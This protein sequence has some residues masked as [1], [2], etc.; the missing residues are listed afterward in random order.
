[1]SK[2]AL[3]GITHAICLELADNGIRNFFVSPN[4]VDYGI[5][6]WMSVED[7]DT[8]PGFYLGPGSFPDS[9]QE[10]FSPISEEAVVLKL[11]TVVP[12]LYLHVATLVDYKVSSSIYHYSQQN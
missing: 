3:D 6:R 5:H 10:F 2:A 4:A 7:E 9:L 1:M 11:M 12:R 8:R